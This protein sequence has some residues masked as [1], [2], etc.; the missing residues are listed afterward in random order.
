MLDAD[1]RADTGLMAPA[2]ALREEI[3]EVVRAELRRDGIIHGDG[4]EITRLDPNRLTTDEKELA[5][6]YR[7]G[8]GG[9]VR[10]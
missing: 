3:N 7:G 10:A 4:A 1:A 9:G 5:S 2:H 6:S 8:R